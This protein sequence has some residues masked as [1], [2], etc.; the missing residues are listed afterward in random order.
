MLV[1]KKGG[2]KIDGKR[3]GKG[4]KIVSDR[5]AC[6]VMTNLSLIA[7]HSNPRPIFTNSFQSFKHYSILQSYLKT[8]Q[9]IRHSWKFCNSFHIPGQKLQ[10]IPSIDRSIRHQSMTSIF[11]T[12]VPY[13]TLVNF[14]E[15]LAVG[16]LNI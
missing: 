14:I 8:T 1:C 16:Y 4:G 12:K 13:P 6:W 3:H 5:L 11:F 9:F 10:F 2:F 7:F 15:L